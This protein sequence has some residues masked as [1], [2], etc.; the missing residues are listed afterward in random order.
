[1]RFCVSSSKSTYEEGREGCGVSLAVAVLFAVLLPNAP[2]IIARGRVCIIAWLLRLV[3]LIVLREGR[4]EDDGVD[5]IERVDP[6]TA[7]VALAAD[8]E[9]RELHR[10]DDEIGLDDAGRTHTRAEDVLR[11]S[12][13]G[14]VV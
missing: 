13:G 10:L 6:L 12:R 3:Y 1:M 11:G 5:V 14:G 7:L 2:C 4:D 8:V 9:H